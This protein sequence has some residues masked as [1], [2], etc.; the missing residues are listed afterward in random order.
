MLAAVVATAIFPEV[1]VSLAAISVAVDIGVI[2]NYEIVRAEYEY[3]RKVAD[4]VNNTMEKHY[5][6]DCQR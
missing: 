3:S 2:L 6:R 1:A 5:S 4:F